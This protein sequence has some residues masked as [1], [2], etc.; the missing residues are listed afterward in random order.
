M[1]SK[2]EIEMA[3]NNI[4]NSLDD[5]LFNI[6]YSQEEM[7]EDLRIVLDKYRELESNNY[8]QNNIINSYIER[9]QKLIEKLEADIETTKKQYTENTLLNIRIDGKLDI[10]EEILKILKGENDE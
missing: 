7:Q 6:T 10:L 1:L 5:E 9:E 2:E 3:I 8:E 4:W